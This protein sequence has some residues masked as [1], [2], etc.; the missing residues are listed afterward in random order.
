MQRYDIPET[1]VKGVCW[2]L[3]AKDLE[4]VKRTAKQAFE[5]RF[6]LER[7][8]MEQLKGDGLFRLVLEEYNSLTE[9]NM[10]IRVRINFFYLTLNEGLLWRAP[11]SVKTTVV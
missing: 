3:P 11:E 1:K 5:L 9:Q 6:V 8:T 10:G 7:A 2:V 4:D